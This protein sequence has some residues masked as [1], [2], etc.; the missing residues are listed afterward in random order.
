MT[1]RNK[2]PRFDSSDSL[3]DAPVLAQLD[4]HRLTGDEVERVVRN[5]LE[6]RGSRGGGV[7]RIIT[8]K[9][10][11]SPD[12]PVLLPKVRTLLKGSL[13]KYVADWRLGDDGGSFV[14]KV[15]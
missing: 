15:R 5:F 2:Q 11:N 4:L 14:V 7:V 3:L 1:R 10:R 12:G 13:A 9:G 6:T 8:G